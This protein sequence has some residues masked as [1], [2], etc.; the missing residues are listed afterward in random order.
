M[1]EISKTIKNDLTKPR[2]VIKISEKLSLRTLWILVGVSLLISCVIY[3]IMAPIEIQLKEIS[4]FGVMELEFMWNAGQAQIIIDAWGSE[5]IQKELFV[6]YLDFAFM[7]AYALLFSGFS[8]IISK[9][10]THLINHLQQSPFTHFLQRYSGYSVL[11]PWFAVVFDIIENLNIIHILK[12]PMTFNTISPTITSLC[13]SIKFGFLVLS[14]I[15]II[16]GTITILLKGKK[17]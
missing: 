17:K 1:D 3:F 10:I 12:N 9:K 2:I 6:T 5:Y 15:S 16:L 4:S 7:P 8:L 14:I 11:F 13:A